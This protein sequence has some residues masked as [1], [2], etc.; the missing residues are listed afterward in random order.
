[1]TQAV[2]DVQNLIFSKQITS[3]IKRAMRGRLQTILAE[4]ERNFNS[5]EEKIKHKLNITR[6]RDIRRRFQKE[7][8]ALKITI[9][10]LTPYMER[11]GEE[12]PMFIVNRAT[13]NK[14]K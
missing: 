9:H 10:F 8:Q 4:H 3:S 11:A 2:K 12:E 5:W 6:Q 7:I 13:K 14:V 1:M